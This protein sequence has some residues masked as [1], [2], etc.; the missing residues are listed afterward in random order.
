MFRRVRSLQLVLTWLLKVY[1]VMIQRRMNGG[2]E[3]ILM[4]RLLVFSLIILITFY[5]V[6]ELIQA[7]V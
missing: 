4:L 5:L 2:D 3:K 1:Y 6:S 7:L